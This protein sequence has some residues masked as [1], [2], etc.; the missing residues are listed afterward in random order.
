MS[1]SYSYS[2]NS[3]LE[4]FQKLQAREE[5]ALAAA[6]GSAETIADDAAL[7]PPAAKRSKTSPSSFVAAAVQFTATGMPSSQVDGHWA[8]VQEAVRTA[9]EQ[10]AQ[11]ILIPELFLGPYFCQSQEP[12]LMK[13]ACE[14]VEHCFIVKIM[15]Q[16]AKQYSV[17]LPVSLFE[18][19]NNTLYN[20]V[21]MVD[22]DGSVLGKYR[23]S[24]IPD[25]VGYNEK[26]YFSPGDTG[27][28]VWKTRVG[29][30]G[31]AICWDQW[32]PEA[33]RAMALQGA[34]ILLYPTAIGSEPQ[35]PTL[36]S[37]DHWQRVMQGHSAANVSNSKTSY[38]VKH[39]S[40]DSV[41]WTTCCYLFVVVFCTADDPCPCQ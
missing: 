10:G 3:L 40:S 35:D 22:A 28:R 7:P 36:D 20:T 23:K 11:L 25:G 6:A 27:F 21:V 39:I 30:V 14:D 15:Q 26:F 17:V 38:S 31:V 37:S 18:R 8:L 13:L 16:L 5:A 2:P 33:A 4:S 1:D 34:D 9:A 24:H 29:N 32:F 12:T 19:D 41:L